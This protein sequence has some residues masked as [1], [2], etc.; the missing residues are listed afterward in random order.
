MLLTFSNDGADVLVL[1][2]DRLGEVGLGEC[3]VRGFMDWN[4]DLV[5][6]TCHIESENT[7]YHLRTRQLKQS[8]NIISDA[9]NMVHVR[10]FSMR[11]WIP[12][13]SIN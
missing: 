4:L 13:Q 8:I 6:M 1:P 11:T 12:R 10:C 9:Y 2:D 3:G 7:Y 5:I